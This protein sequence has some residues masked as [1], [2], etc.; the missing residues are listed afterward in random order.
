VKR[1]E[2]PIRGRHLVIVHNSDSGLVRNAVG[3]WKRLSRPHDPPCALCALT[4]GV[5]GVSP[6]WKKYLD[7][8]SEPVHD[9]MRDQWRADHASSSWRNIALPAILLQTGPKLERLVSAKEISK[10]ATIKEL[11][12]KI[13]E[14]LRAHPPEQRAAT[15]RREPGT[16]A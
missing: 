14:A 2:P 8:Q 6:Q 7:S 4:R 10:S 13:D 16:P 5:R 3:V 1:S 15:P 9:V 12:D 11:T